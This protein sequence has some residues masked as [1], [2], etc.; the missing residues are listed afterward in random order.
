ML[1]SSSWSS[2]PS[3][4]S[5]RRAG[6][7][8]A[9]LEVLEDRRLLSVT[10][11]ST[12]NGSTA[13]GNGVSRE[14]SVSADGRFVVFSST[15]SNLVANDTNN[16]A[17][18]FLHDTTNN[19]TTLIS[20]NT[21]GGVGNGASD[22]PSI[23]A[24]GRFVS[25]RSAASD[26]LPAGVDTNSQTDILVRDLPNNTTKRVTA[27]STGA[28]FTGNPNDFSAEPFTSSDGRWVAFSSRASDLVSGVTD[29]DDVP[30]GGGGLGR[31]TD[32][33]LRD[34]QSTDPATA[35]KMVSVNTAGNVSGNARSF[36]ASV[37]AD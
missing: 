27:D 22:E 31:A 1:R 10:V 25:F 13:L 34:L 2:R 37:S 11:V 17:D 7:A 19:A 20:V 6:L 9:A 32:V 15:A 35:T 29:R 24:D 30:T 36:D 26:L 28:N 33:F 16:A 21:A 23:S 14:P 8:Q 5:Q 12:Q 3:S 4:R 18:V